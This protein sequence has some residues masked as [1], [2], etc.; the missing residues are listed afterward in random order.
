MSQTYV[1][2]EFHPSFF[3]VKDRF[4][5]V[6]L[7]QGKSDQGLYPLCN[8]VRPSPRPTT[9]FTSW[10]L[11]AQWHSLLRHHS[12]RIIHQVFPSYSLPTISNKIVSICSPFQ[13][14]KSHRL[15]FYLSPSILKAPSDLL[16]MDVW[17]PSPQISSNGNLYY[18]SI[19]DDFFKYVWLFLMSLKS[20]VS[21]IFLQF[22]IEVGKYFECTIKSL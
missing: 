1:Y 2:F 5:R 6:T 15:P 11:V 4:S 12:L 8:L 16:F 9:F 10:I 17:G 7:L 19:M 21:F 20:F 3:Y 13:L 14:W 18:L 22:K